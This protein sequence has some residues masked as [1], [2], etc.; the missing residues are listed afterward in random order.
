MGS[1]ARARCCSLIIGPTIDIKISVFGT[2]PLSSIFLSM[3][4]LGREKKTYII[5]TR[6]DVFRYAV[7]P[8]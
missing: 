3:H 5:L 8:H 7:H 1:R 4:S 2:H 6:E